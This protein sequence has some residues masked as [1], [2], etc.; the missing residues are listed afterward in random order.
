MAIFVKRAR[1]LPCGDPP[2]TPVFRPRS[3]DV[4]PLYTAPVPEQSAQ[5]SPEAISRLIAAASEGDAVASKNLF[6][7]VYERLRAIAGDH[8]AGE[9]RGHTLQATALVHEAYMRLVGDGGMEWASRVGFF[10]AAAEAMRRI[11]IEH[12]R[13]HGAAKR[14][15]GRCRLDLGS[16]LDLADADDPEEIVAFDGALSRLGEESPQT[17]SVVRLRFFA[18]LSVEETAAALGISPRTVNREWTYARAWLYQ[19]L[20]EEEG[21]AAEEG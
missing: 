1:P 9:R 15:G 8:M 20:K 6:P 11:L 21:L 10:H 4:Q 7:L 17:G 16:V 12:A 18:G 5:T 14:G 19:E 13:S 2:A 3:R